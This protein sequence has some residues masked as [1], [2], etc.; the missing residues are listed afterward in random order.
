MTPTTAPAI[1]ADLA[2][3]AWARLTEG[4]PPEKVLDWLREQSGCE[5]VKACKMALYAA[6]EKAINAV[7]AG[8]GYPNVCVN[9][10]HQYRI[11]A[12]ARYVGAGQF[13]KAWSKH[14]SSSDVGMRMWNYALPV[15]ALCRLISSLPE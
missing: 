13:D 3:F 12:F 5:D 15:F 1:P 10:V 14:V 11:H 6:A 4:E 7:S 2:A 8:S 9:G